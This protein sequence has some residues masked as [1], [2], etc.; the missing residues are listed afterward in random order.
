MTDLCILTGGGGGIGREV[1]RRMAERNIR[2]LLVGRRES[3]ERTLAAIGPCPAGAEL[4]EMDLENYGDGFERLA[5]AVRQ[6][7][8]LRP[9]IVLAASRLDDRLTSTP[10]ERLRDYERVYRTNLI[11]NLAVLEACLPSLLQARHGRV[12]FFAGGGAAYPFPQFPAYASSK[13]STV[14]TVETLAEAHPATTGLS[15]V[16]LSPGA[17]DTPMLAQVLAAGC[18]VRTRTSASEAVGFIDAYLESDSLILSGKFVHVRDEWRP[19]LSGGRTP[20]PDRFL[21]RRTE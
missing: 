4:F 21:L 6:I 14:R 13:V 20:E 11:G 17:V 7:A 15:F 16:C 3:N 18:K 1:A 9:G 10:L 2:L 19:Y 12:V 5:S 8:P